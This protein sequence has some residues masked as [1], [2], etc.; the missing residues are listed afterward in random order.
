MRL[1]I[2]SYSFQHTFQQGMMDV[3]GFLET[4]A[5]R[6]RVREVD[7][8]N[9]F[10]IERSA[11]PVFKLAD[12]S[13]IRKIREALD[14]RELTV[15]N[16]AVDGAHLWDPDPETRRRLRENAL[17]HL[18]AAE[19]LGAKTVRIDTGGSYASSETMGEE[20]FEH[21]VSL[22]REYARRA[23]EGGYRIGPEN[24]MGASLLP[25]EMKRLA[26]A[27]EHP[28]F[29]FLLHLN[30]WK[31]D[32][33]EGDAT[34]APWTFHTHIDGRT[35]ALPEAARSVRALLDAGYA[36]VWGIEHNAPERQYD[37]VEWMVASVRRLVGHA[38]R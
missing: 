28:A 21:T 22:Y 10:F 2:M 9:G 16:F 1:S 12:E 11:G 13:Y 5:H 26:E 4:A 30:R 37:E 38:M 8:W 27:V 17:E 14:E 23:E 29:G 24:H 15:A 32:R 19:I 3:F 34:V 18:R 20:Q 25:A 7:L 6:Y 35:V 36:G 33:E 31:A